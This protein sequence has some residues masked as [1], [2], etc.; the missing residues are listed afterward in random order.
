MGEGTNG[1]T[2]LR[3]IGV[4]VSSLCCLR[5]ENAYTQSGRIANPTERKCEFLSLE[6]LSFG[7][8]ICVGKRKKII[9]GGPSDLLYKNQRLSVLSDSSAFQI[10]IVSN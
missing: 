9:S 5:I 6:F 3:I 4:D 1:R 2:C 7:T 8:L 10:Q